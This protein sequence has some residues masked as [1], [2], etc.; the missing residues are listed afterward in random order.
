M[1]ATLREGD[2]YV[3]QTPDGGEIKNVLGEPVMDGGLENAVYL[4]LFASETGGHWMNEYLS[5]DEKIECRFYS[6]VKGAPKTA[7]T[8]TRAEDLALLDLAWMIR[9]QLAD[10]INAT[11][12]SADAMT[13]TIL[14]EVKKN[15]TVVLSTQYNV[16]WSYQQQDP[17]SGRI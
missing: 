13:A 5:E 7:S 17:A 12:T 3:Y 10:E 9:V 16:N 11:I 14:V 4:S 1:M 8:M 6:Y 15:G 2:L